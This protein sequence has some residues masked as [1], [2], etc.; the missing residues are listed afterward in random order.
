VPEVHAVLDKMAQFA[1]P[2]RGGAWKRYT[3]KRIRNV[4]NIGIGGSDLGPV[5]AHEAAHP[6]AER[7]EPLSRGGLSRANPPLAAG[8]DSRRS[9]R[10]AGSDRRERSPAQRRMNRTTALAKPSSSQESVVALAWR[11]TSSLALPMAML[12][13]E[14]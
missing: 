14:R 5:I 1:Q 11:F 8:S 6:T 7:H 13:P 10:D 3:G 9:G 2:V 12:K 4:V